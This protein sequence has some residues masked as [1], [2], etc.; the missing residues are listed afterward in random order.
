M[1]A[2]LGLPSRPQISRW[3]VYAL[4]AGLFT[5][6]PTAVITAPKASANS[7]NLTS[8]PIGSQTLVTFSQVQ[9]CV[10][11]IPNGVSSVRVLVVGGGSS[12][13]AGQAGV[14]WP[15]G[16]GGGAVV[17]QLN[18]ST[19]PGATVAVA[20]GAGGAAINTQGLASTSE[21][22]GGQSKFATLTANGGVAPVNTLGPGGASGN[23]NAGGATGS[24][25]SC[26][27][28]GAGGAASTTTGGPGVNSD[29]S[30]STLMY[31]SGG[32]GSNGST[33]SASSG[34]GVN[35]VAP[36]ANRGGG[37]SQLSS[38]SGLASAGA[39]GVVIVRY[40]TP[41][42]PNPMVSFSANGGTGSVAAIS[43]TTGAT[44]Q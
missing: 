13:A 4:L 2:K 10:W 28:G 23:G 37:G 6:L 31:G 16:G 27:G 26:G 21:N 40:T 24:P 43:E 32:A 5:S 18:F 38:G 14:W 35:S 42:N 7:C 41:I 30:G 19:S 33:G 29:I 1:L 11:T 12:G 25:T 34:G 36:A 17:T 44:L 15:Q 8:T 3:L 9:S 39:S 22:N 20:V